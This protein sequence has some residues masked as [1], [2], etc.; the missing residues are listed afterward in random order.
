MHVCMQMIRLVNLYFSVAATC[1]AKATTMTL[2][3]FLIGFSEKNTCGRA[4]YLIIA[5][6]MHYYKLKTSS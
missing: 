2:Y 4:G 1:T 3:L 5:E 6:V